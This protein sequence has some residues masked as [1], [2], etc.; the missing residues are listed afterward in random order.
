[1]KWMHEH[2]VWCDQ[3]TN[4]RSVFSQTHAHIREWILLDSQS[5]VDYFTNPSLVKDIHD[6]KE[7][8]M[9]STNAGQ[10]MTK[11]KANVPKWGKVC[12]NKNG[13]TNIFILAS[14]IKRHSVMF[15]SDKEAAFLVHTPEGVIKFIMSPEGMFYHAP[16][17]WRACELFHMWACPTVQDLKKII[18]MNSVQD[19]HVTLEDIKLVEAIYGPDLPSL[20]GKIKRVHHSPVVE[21]IVEIPAELVFRQHLVDLCIGTFYVNGLLFLS[22]MQQA[23]SVQDLPKIG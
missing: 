16:N 7:C 6:S 2:T 5:C 1:M 21:D 4:S 14:M 8:L 18:K 20:K 19:C 3:C 17:Y 9:L 15:D 11:Q 12:L 23:Y 10:S 13:S 22:S